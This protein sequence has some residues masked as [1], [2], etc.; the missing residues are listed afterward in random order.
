MDQ[1]GGKNMRQ[2]RPKSPRPDRRQP[3]RYLRNR[4]EVG[5][6]EMIQFVRDFQ[7][8]KQPT[9][10]M[11]QKKAPLPDIKHSNE[12]R[13][14]NTDIPDGVLEFGSRV[15]NGIVR[16]QDLR[17][18]TDC[19]YSVNISPRMCGRIDAS[20]GLPSKTISK[21]PSSIGNSHVS[22]SYSFAGQHNKS[23]FVVANHKHM[24]HQLP[25]I[26]RDDLP[27]R[28]NAPPPCFTPTDTLDSSDELDGKPIDY[29]DV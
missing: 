21:T 29:I 17:Q 4:Q 15:G 14:H 25:P 28:P 27:E 24:I 13:Q 6:A 18:S 19:F 12:I 23:N 2:P 16:S 5:A 22:R 1:M 3:N 10:M 9:M 26:V 20:R 7:I 11:L 8:E